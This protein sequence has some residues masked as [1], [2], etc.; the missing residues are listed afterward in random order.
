MQDLLIYV[1]L[2]LCIG[3]M[4]GFFGI[5][6]GFILTPTLIL[7]GFS[8][9]IAI[10][11]SLLYTV[12]T[13]LSGVAAHFR[14][15]H[16]KWETS[17]II[18]IS[19]VIATQFAHPFVIFLEKYQLENT[20]I[21]LMYLVLI[22]YF[23]ISILVSK[24]PS[25]EQVAGKTKFAYGKIVLIGLFAGFISTALG[26]GG[27]FIIVPLLMSVL[28]FQPKYAVGTSLLSV[29]MIVVAGF[30]TY[31]ST[32]ELDYGVI[33]SLIIGALIGGQL[34]AMVTNVY[35]DKQVRYFLAGLYIA[36]G[37]SLVFKLFQLDFVGL[38]FLLIY[39]LYMLIHFVLHTLKLR[40]KEK[41]VG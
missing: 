24:S 41:E 9:V 13:S 34:G 4:S 6:G 17:I 36:T 3:V 40:L 23:S 20:V 33:V 11:T 29:F 14:L 32:V 18:G 28:A 30:A 10:A 39:C 31:A 7:M 15:K 27:G 38:L 19:G 12:A 22:L 21:P 25:K 8:P 37:V 1:I 5:G 26:V 35:E 2:G 16:I